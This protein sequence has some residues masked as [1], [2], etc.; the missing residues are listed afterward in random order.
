MIFIVS[1]LLMFRRFAY[2]SRPTRTRC[3][4]QHEVWGGVYI[5]VIM[6]ATTPS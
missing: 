5:T 4:A 3:H 2:V 1:L 6:D